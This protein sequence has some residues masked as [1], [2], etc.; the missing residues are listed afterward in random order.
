MVCLADSLIDRKARMTAA[1]VVAGLG[2]HGGGLLFSLKINHQTKLFS[3]GEED[4]L[5]QLLFSTFVKLLKQTLR[6]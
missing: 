1:Y 3:A 5:L 4:S 2:G 6:N